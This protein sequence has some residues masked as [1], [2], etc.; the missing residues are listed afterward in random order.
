MTKSIEKE[1]WGMPCAVD[2][3]NKRVYLKCESAIT[4]MGVGALVEKY[5]PGYTGHIASADYLEQLKNQLVN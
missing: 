4:A 3:K 5:Y 1:L 2:H